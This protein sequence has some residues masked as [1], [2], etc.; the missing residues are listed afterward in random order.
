MAGIFNF[1][2]KSFKD[3]FAKTF[4]TPE[5]KSQEERDRQEKLGEKYL[6][7]AKDLNLKF[8]SVSG[9]KRKNKRRSRSRTRVSLKKKTSRS[10]K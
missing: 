5:T 6:G 8:D 2:K 1:Y 10:K 4:A 9:G 7:T 3:P